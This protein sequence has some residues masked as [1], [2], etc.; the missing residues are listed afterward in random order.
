MIAATMVMV[1][2]ALALFPEVP[3]CRGL[4]ALVVECPAR[5][6]NALARR[7]LIFVVIMSFI[8]IAGAGAIAGL[9]TADLAMLLAWDASLYVDTI[10]AVW[11][12]AAAT[13]GLAV[14]R[15]SWAWAARFVGGRARQR[16]VRRGRPASKP[17]NDDERRGAFALVA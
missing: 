3:V 8:V 11:T 15:R 14:V 1:M 2:L 12:V 17:A 10:I 13:R 9:V 7:Q 16:A 6:L 5:W 4:S